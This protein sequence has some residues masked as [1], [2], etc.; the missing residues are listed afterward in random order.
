[1]PV[2]LECP[3]CGERENVVD[4]TATLKWYCS[5]C[6]D[7]RQVVGDYDSLADAET[8]TDKI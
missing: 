4:V 1:M 5:K 8:N 2:A 6:G 3:D 7:R